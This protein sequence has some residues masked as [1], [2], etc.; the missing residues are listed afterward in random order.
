MAPVGRN[1]GM[2]GR[3]FLRDDA[4]TPAPFALPAQDQRRIRGIRSKKISMEIW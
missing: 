3:F 4:G 1:A 2:K